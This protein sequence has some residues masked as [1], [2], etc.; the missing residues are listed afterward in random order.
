MGVMLHSAR[1][2]SLL[3]AAFVVAGCEK[4]A[5]QESA[6][7]AP[8]AAAPAPPAA[9]A[10]KAKLALF[11][12][13]RASFDEPALG[14]NAARVE[15]GQKLY[16]D[17]RLSKGQ[18]ISC[19]SCHDLA[20]YGQDGEATSPGHRGQRGGRNSPTTLNAA[21][22][23]RQFWDGRMANVEEQAHGPVTNPIEM[24]MADGAAVEKVLRSI[25]EYV[26]S[27]AAA[28]ADDKQPVTFDNMARAIAA[29]E[30]RLV[31]PSRWDAFL[32]G[33]E[34]ALTAPEKAGFGTFVAKGCAACHNGELVGGGTFQ[35]LGVKEPYPT[36]D[37]GR[38][39]ATKQEADRSVFKV[40]SLRNIAK[41][42]PYFHDGQV[43]TLE[44]AVRLMG[45]H[46]LG[47][48]LAPEEI[49]SIVAFLGALTGDLPPELA[50]APELPK[51]TKAT[52]KPDLH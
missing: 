47:F 15:L 41:T 35:K 16:F 37:L 29:F 30:R 34:G 48:A 2:G 52:P 13:L 3:L 21:G 19:S 18:Q 5:A 24:A 27:F 22:H 50:K 49:A 9:A 43:K 12:P 8:A 28:F 14:T 40:P 20:K 42:A 33:D 44:E 11:K 45:K 1:V 26:R 7:P 25:P 23:V 17:P 39:E 31:T 6:P 51:S 10:D 38:F 36:A 46:Q 32:R 4:K